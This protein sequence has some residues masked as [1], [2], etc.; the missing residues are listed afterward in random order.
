MATNIETLLDRDWMNRSFILANS[1]FQTRADINRWSKFSTADL[2]YTGTGL[3]QNNTINSA[4][5]F[6]PICDMPRP[7]LLAAKEFNIALG[8]Q[9]NYVGMGPRY[10]EAID[11]NR[12]I[13]HLRFGVIKYKGLLTFFTSFYDG[14]AA[15]LARYG[16]VGI[17]YYIGALAGTLL[18]LPLAPFVL[19]GRAWD[20]IMGRQSTKFMDF[21]PTMPLFWMRT[22]VIYN[23]LGA[24]MG[25]IART[26]NNTG[27]WG[28]G[29]DN[30][31]D[32][33]PTN[34]Q[35]YTEA[36]SRIMPEFFDKNG[37]VDIFKIANGAARRENDHR[38][39]IDAIAESAVNSKDLYDKILNY[40]DSKPVDNVKPVVSFENYL[41]TYHESVL[42]S[43][44]DFGL[45]S[46]G[47]ED[48]LST[49]ID[50]YSSGRDP[51]ALT[52]LQ[53]ASRNSE[54]QTQNAVSDSS[55]T[56][57]STATGIDINANGFLAGGGGGILGLGTNALNIP[58]SSTSNSRV[59]ATSQPTGNNTTHEVD[60]NGNRISPSSVTGTVGVT[61]PSTF[62]KSKN[63]E[64][65]SVI[66]ET[67]NA[68]GN[69][70][71]S[72]SRGWFADAAEFFNLEANLGSAFV[73]LAVNYTGAGTTT[74]SNSLKDTNLHGVMNGLSGTAR[75]AR[76]SAA[77]FNTGFGFIDSAVGFVRGLF[78]GVMDKV[79][80]QGL[81][82]LAGNAFVD[83]PKQWD[84]STATFPTATFT[85]ELRSP[86]G[87]DLARYLNL[88]LPIATLLAG[89]LP[90]SA[91]PQ[92][93]TSPSVCECYCQGLAAIRLGMITD[94]TIT[95][96]TGNLGYNSNRQPLGF[97]VQFTV[98]DM[99]SLMHAP[100]G[101]GFNP[102]NPFRRVFDDDNAFNDYM[103]TITGVHM[104]DMTNS[105]RKLAIRSAARY[106]DYKAMLSP[107]H[108][109]SRLAG[110]DS[111]MM[112]NKLLGGSYYPGT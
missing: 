24:N 40:I 104:R 23:G 60:S 97:D 1:D 4:P 77:D 30:F 64:G 32:L 107:A 59:P 51:D 85:M 73:N 48:A 82:A 2:K 35:A 54:N 8:S 80:L 103:A 112:L 15:Q 78:G 33:D 63:Q 102:L 12:Q 11:D 56:A 96:G 76:V 89:A 37:L 65:M 88:Y 71:T 14:E 45:E 16:R 74:F 75:D 26:F 87:N 17:G 105:Y 22:Q 95:A 101:N 47:V 84:N 108:V 86:Y 36:M 110:T 91:G 39:K 53:T 93:Y 81:M 106:M 38:K 13:V 109:A 50:D 69:T 10:S 61:D 43:M 57:D 7:G 92:S 99:S 67:T 29:A 83:I 31:D 3:G 94:L 72:I 21:K 25:V 28:K 70:E 44:K 6:T 27:H 90:Q 79:H 41:R 52:K 18:T 58:G 19:A 98:A 9:L 42:G 68:D 46:T 55:D 62:D 100:I 49:A 20:F 5:A 111:V 66:V 34:E